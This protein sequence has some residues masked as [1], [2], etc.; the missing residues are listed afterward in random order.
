MLTAAACALL[1]ASAGAQ[2]TQEPAPVGDPPPEP[3][4]DDT[5]PPADPAQPPTP[6]AEQTLTAADVADAPRPGAEHGRV[7]PIDTGDGAGRVLGRVILWIPRLPLELVM[8]PIR[9]GLYLQEKFQV[10]DKVASIFL[11]EDGKL[12]IYPTAFAETGFGLNIGARAFVRDLFGANEKL[13][14]R[15]GFGGKFNRVFGVDLDTGDRAGR[16]AFGVDARYENRDRDRFFGYGNG[17]VVPPPPP[18]MPYHVLDDSVSVSS[19]FKLNIWRVTPRLRLRLPHR[20]R[21]QLAGGYV[22]K[23]FE[24]DATI[25][26]NDQRTEDVYDIRGN[27]LPGFVRGTRFAYGELE[28][29]YDSRRPADEYDAPGIRGTGGLIMAFLGRQHGLLEDEPQFYR[30]G[31]DL[32]RYFRITPGPRVFELRAYGE[33]VTGPRDQVPFTELARLGGNDVLRGYTS[34]RFR[35]RV[36]TVVQGGYLW[37]IGRALAG[38]L[39]VDVGKVH[40]SVSA[41]DLTNLRVGFGIALEAYS[42]AGMLVRTAVASSIDGDLF[43]IFSFNPVFDARSRVERY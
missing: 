38:E 23:E 41:I 39:F 19:R 26:G 37:Q 16:V 35:D 6:P 14:L 17:D 20:L 25:T 18:G 31:V 22:N 21:V 8:Q 7:D 34:D 4:A 24:G 32:Q 33:M 2:P 3:A 9:G 15:V 1:P 36:A 10:A 29:A 42:A 5:A 11:S 27:A 40:S 43:F 13:A 30:L 28:L 12:G